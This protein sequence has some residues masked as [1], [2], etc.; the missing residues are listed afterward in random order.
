MKHLKINIRR[1]TAKKNLKNLSIRDVLR[2][3]LLHKNQRV[4]QKKVK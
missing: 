1:S 4:Q 2:F 3:P